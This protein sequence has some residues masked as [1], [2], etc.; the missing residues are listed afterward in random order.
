ML[1]HLGEAEAAAAVLDAL[2]RMLADGGPRTRDLGGNATTADVTSA[3][4]SSFA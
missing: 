3:L 4:V 2:E 1:E